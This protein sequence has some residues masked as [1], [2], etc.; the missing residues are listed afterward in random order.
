M[1]S[2]DAKAAQTK[3]Q[4]RLAVLSAGPT[5]RIALIIGNSV[6]DHAARLNNP[7]NDAK[8]IASALRRIGFADVTERFD[9]TYRRLR[10]VLKAFG[11]KAAAADWAVVYFAGHGMQVN[12][13]TYL[14]PTDAKLARASHIEDEAIPLPYVLSKVEEARQLR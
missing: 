5:H 6:Y 4:L 8:E 9:L 10:D 7:A 13:A 11:D 12:P 1:S 2:R 3:A 14:I